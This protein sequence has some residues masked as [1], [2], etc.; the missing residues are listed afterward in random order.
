MR[1][2]QA[3]HRFTATAEGA[4]YDSRLVVGLSG[5]NSLNRWLRPLLFS[6]CM[7][8]VW[9]SHDVEEAGNVERILPAL[10]AASANKRH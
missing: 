3:H 1:I 9:L 10:Y 6:D 2:S 8:Q 5:A 7:A 4:R